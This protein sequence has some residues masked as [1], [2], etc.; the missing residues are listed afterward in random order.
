MLEVSKRI[1]T[2]FEIALVFVFGSNWRDCVK[3]CSECGSYVPMVTT[4]TAA[5]LE[6]ASIAE[7]YR[8]AETGELHFQVTVKGTLLVCFSSLL[9]ASREPSKRNLI[10]NFC[11]V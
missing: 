9:V 1:E 7:I 5:T 10:S 11:D 6:K 8:R 2:D 3:W 4:L